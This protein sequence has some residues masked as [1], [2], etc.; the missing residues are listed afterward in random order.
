M[1]IIQCSWLH[2]YYINNLCFLRLYCMHIVLRILL[3]NLNFTLV[4][5]LAKH[6]CRINYIAKDSLCRYV[7]ASTFHVGSQINNRWQWTKRILQACHADPTSGDL[8]IKRTIMRIH[9]R[10]TWKGINKEV[11]ELVCT[12]LWHDVYSCIRICLHISCVHEWF[13]NP[14]LLLVIF[15]NDGMVKWL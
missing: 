13:Y 2:R 15:V 4:A 9:E 7:Y 8:G 3:D 10:F 14:R 11:A 5:S 12:I 1:Q 6:I